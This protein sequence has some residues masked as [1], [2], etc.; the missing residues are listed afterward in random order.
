V[1]G[2]LLQ[3]AQSASQITRGIAWVEWDVGGKNTWF[4]ARRRRGAEVEESNRKD[5]KDLNRKFF[6]LAAFY[7]NRSNHFLWVGEWLAS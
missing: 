7:K 5:R 4:F 6:G 2:R 1:D 3:A